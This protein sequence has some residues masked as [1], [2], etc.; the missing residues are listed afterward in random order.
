MASGEPLSSSAILALASTIRDNGSSPSFCFGTDVQPFDTGNS[1]VY[2]VSFP[3]R[4]TWAIH[5]PTQGATG[6]TGQSLASF[7]ESQA[8]ILIQLEQAGFRWSPRLI[9]YDIGHDNIIKLPYLVQSWIQGTAL[10]WTDTTPSRPKDREKILR[11]VVDIRLELAGCTKVSRMGQILPRLSKLTLSYRPRD[12][13]IGL[14]NQSCRWQ[15]DTSRSRRRTSFQRPR[16]P[17][18]PRTAS[19]RCPG[20][21]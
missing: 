14:S 4:V 20:P 12:V 9:H 7:M 2:A 21:P 16:L 15:G 3:D 11:R 1:S 19:V 8:A 6:L 13:C 18:T 10:E 5:V 17:H